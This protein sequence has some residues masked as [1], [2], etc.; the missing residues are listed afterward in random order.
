MA[1]D[2][3]SNKNPEAAPVPATFSNQNPSAPKK[4]NP[5]A[6]A[7]GM[8]DK[9]IPLQLPCDISSARMEQRGSASELS[10]S[11]QYTLQDLGWSSGRRGLEASSFSTV[12]R[13]SSRPPISIV[14][15]DF[16]GHFSGLSWLPYPKQTRKQA[17]ENMLIHYHYPTEGQ[18][19]GQHAQ[20]AKHEAFKLAQ[21]VLQ[22]AASGTSYLQSRPHIAGMS[23]KSTGPSQQHEPSTG[24][25]VTKRSGLGELLH[26]ESFQEPGARGQPRHVPPQHTQGS[27]AKVT[28]HVSPNRLLVVMTVQCIF[29]TLYIHEQ[30]DH[31]VC[32]MSILHPFWIIELV[33]TSAE[34]LIAPFD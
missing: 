13:S 18:N 3:Q 24:Y 19:A 2:R 11:E 9:G 8:L 5:S 23:A 10:E 4:Q 27:N 15:K 32:Y 17:A 12:K 28:T 31:V 30:Y 16:W 7:Q 29:H 20:H 14:L 1:M 22:Q 34:L 25:M 21:Q 6:P 26:T 33:Y